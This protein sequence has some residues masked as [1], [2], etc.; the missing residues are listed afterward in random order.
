MSAAYAFSP[1]PPLSLAADLGESEARLYGYWQDIHPGGDLL[2]GRQHFD[3]AEL[4]S[5]H[6]SLLQHLWLVDVE[7]EPLR[8]RLRLVGSAV[9]MTSPFAR[10]GHYIDE[11]IDPASRTETL[12]SSF[13]RLVETAEP[14]FRRGWP[15]L[16]SI[17]NARE[18]SRLSL[19]LA[20]DGRTVDMILNLTT[21]V[22]APAMGPAYGRLT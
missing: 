20:A 7:R 3:P 18:L 5:R 17:R 10:A 12:Q 2:P 6:P 16:P 22:G 21:Y 14:E 13:S 8:F 4:G 1:E 11:F 19:P 15:R 9:Y